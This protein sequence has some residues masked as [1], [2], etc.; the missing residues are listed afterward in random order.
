METKT[1]EKKRIMHAHLSPDLKKKYKKRSLGLRKGD[2]VKI[3]RG[4]F[5]GEEEKVERISVIKTKVYLENIKKRKVDGKDAPIPIH[6]SNLM[7][8]EIDTSDSWRMKILKR[9][10]K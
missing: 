5:K 3:M 10:E 1:S 2:K 6:P 9:V 8:T 7:I 4:K